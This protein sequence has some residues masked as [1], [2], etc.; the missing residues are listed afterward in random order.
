MWEAAARD[1]T[2]TLSSL[3]PT[4]TRTRTK[5]RAKTTSCSCRKMLWVDE[6]TGLEGGGG[7]TSNYR[8]EESFPFLG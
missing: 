5:R 3:K 8:G 4:E 7:S 1:W 2:Q 6:L